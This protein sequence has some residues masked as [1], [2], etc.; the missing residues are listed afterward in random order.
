MMGIQAKRIIKLELM[1]RDLS[2]G[3]LV[4]L[5]KAH[6][7]NETKASIDNKISR[8]TFSASFFINC[9]YVMGCKT[10]TLSEYVPL[11]LVETVKE[12]ENEY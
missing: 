12:A 6:G 7:E 4:S 11:S 5:L 8:G 2:T 1:R 3:D 10:I 9:L